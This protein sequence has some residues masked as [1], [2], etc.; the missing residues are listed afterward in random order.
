MLHETHYGT[1][2]RRPTYSAIS[3]KPLD[4]GDALVKV[5][6]YF[7]GVKAS[8]WRSMTTE[9]KEAM[10]QEWTAMLPAPEPV[11]PSAPVYEDMAFEDLKTLATERGIDIT[12]RR[13]SSAV[14]NALRAADVAAR[15]AEPAE[16]PQEGE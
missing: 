9:E 16:A 5:G 12:G 4:T 6:G 11:E 1:H 7:I 3:G 8:E 2:R 13:S 14:I 10:R 15:F